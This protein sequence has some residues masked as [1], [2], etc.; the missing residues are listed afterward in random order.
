LAPGGRGFLCRHPGCDFNKLTAEPVLEHMCEHGLD[1]REVVDGKFVRC[2]WEGCGKLMAVTVRPSGSLHL[3]HVKAHEAN[4]EPASSAPRGF[5]CPHKPCNAAFPTPD[6]AWKCG[7]AHGVFRDSKKWPCLWEHCG[8]T[9]ECPSKY[10]AHEPKHTGI[11]P[12]TCQWCGKGHQQASFAASCCIVG[13][14]CVCGWT[15]SADRSKGEARTA[16]A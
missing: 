10:R 7:E 5:V 1:G 4:H 11:W 9:F 16:D 6:A 12:F 15:K 3:G 2:L 8:W 13:A 14:A